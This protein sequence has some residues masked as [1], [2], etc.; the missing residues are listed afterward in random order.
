[1]RKSLLVKKR[2]EN[3]PDKRE[4]CGGTQRQRSLRGTAKR[5]RWPGQESTGAVRETMPQ[6]GGGGKVGQGALTQPP[7]NWRI[8]GSVGARR[9]M[10]IAR[11]TEMTPDSVWKMNC[12]GWKERRTEAES[13]SAANTCR[14]PKRPSEARPGKRLVYLSSCLHGLSRNNF[15]AFAKVLSQQDGDL[16]RQP[17]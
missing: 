17:A 10:V 11:F 7:R 9:V 1:M 2:G 13:A 8:T 5:S 14:E 16:S 15:L 12:G 6:R 3:I 4:Q